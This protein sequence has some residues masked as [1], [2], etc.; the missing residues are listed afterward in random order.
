VEVD[1][2]FDGGVG[3]VAAAVAAQGGLA[4]STD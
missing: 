1:E 4:V 2:A 3:A